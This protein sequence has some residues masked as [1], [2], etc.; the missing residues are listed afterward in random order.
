MRPG[1]HDDAWPHQ[2]ALV[3]PEV[4]VCEP[5]AV[6]EFRALAPAGCRVVS[7]DRGE[8]A[9]WWT[10]GAV[11]G[12][13]TTP[14]L[15][16]L[17]TA[18]VA[19]ESIERTASADP[20]Y[21]TFTSGSTG[22]MKAAVLSHGSFLA[23]LPAFQMFT[24]FAPAPG[25]VF[26][27]SLGWAISAGLRTLAFPAWYFGFPVVG[28]GHR[29][30]D[31]RAVAGF[32]TGLRVS[33][34]LLMPQVLR[35]LRQLGDGVL[36][37]DWSALRVIAYSGEAISGDLRDWLESTLGVVLNPYYG[38]T[39]ISYVASTC[40]AWFPSGP[41]E[42]GRRVPGRELA[43]LAEDT[44]LVA[45]PGAAGVLA[46]RRSD[47]GL[48]LGYLYPGEDRARFD[49]SSSTDE[50]FLTGDLGTIDLDGNVRYL[51]RSGQTIRS[52]AGDA[53]PP[54]D[55]EEA[56]LSVTAVREAAVVQHQ[57]DPPGEVC[58]CVSLA[59]APA[60][61][62]ALARA[63]EAA[64]IERFQEH[65]RVTRVVVFDDLPKTAATAKINRRLAAEILKTGT[66]APLATIVLS[67]SVNDPVYTRVRT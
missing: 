44:L 47:P 9:A 27:P 45:E 2:L 1:V 67:E 65:V 32:L 7:A 66:P 29:L 46:V 28:A 21:I 6:E 48:G 50:F 53:I 18:G 24:N 63:V 25:D 13:G 40:R 51:G 23:G 16:E 43:V 49:A 38:A 55:V 37:Y 54:M 59:A 62:R 31:G 39:E 4:V 58:A 8:W 12:S 17:L 30:A 52:I 61:E 56:V 11:G 41:G 33:V 57:E 42:V 5:A 64:V 26:F 15:A 60:D 35:D 3:R 22:A 34:A 36:E 10:G 20:A 14:S 19:G